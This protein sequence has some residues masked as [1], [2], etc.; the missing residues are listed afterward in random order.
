MINLT[1]ETFR[2]R[3]PEV[4]IALKEEDLATFLSQ[5]TI[6]VVEA[7]EALIVAG[8]ETE[9]LYFVWE[10]QLDVMLPGPNGEYKV[11]TVEE[12]EL[13][14]EISLMSPGA[15]TATVRSE[16]GCIALHLDRTSL[17]KYWDTHPQAAS[18]FLQ[19]ISRIVARRIRNVN[20][21]ISALQGGDATNSNQLKTAQH[22]LVKG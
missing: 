21:S 11:A 20:A 1:V 15:T 9:S 13:L 8:T 4:G 22:K 3:F 7:S 5:L 10:G 18:V 6:E 12:G 17:T 2:Q 19:A 16:L 14:G